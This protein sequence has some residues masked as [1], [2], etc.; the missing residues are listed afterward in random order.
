MNLHAIVSSAV[1]SINPSVEVKIYRST[2]ST[3]QPD[4]TRVPTYSA[5]YVLKAQIQ[6][7]TYQDIIQVN[8]LNIQGHRRGIYLS[9]DVESIVRLHG[10]GGDLI[11]FPDGSM[12]LVAQVLENWSQD[13]WCKVVA[14]LQVDP[15]IVPQTPT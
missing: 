8:G 13:G 1:A 2:G 12:W 6:A 4:G 9:G 14:T 3:T 11:K 7:L 15:P 5:P 10:R